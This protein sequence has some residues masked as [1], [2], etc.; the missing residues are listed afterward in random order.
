MGSRHR[1]PRAR[2]RGWTAAGL[3]KAEVR[4][5]AGKTAV[6]TSSSHAGGATGRS[7]RAFARGAAPRSPDS[8]G[9]T[10]PIRR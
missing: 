7:D 2:H 10:F 4:R 6:G 8:L 1:S 9:A 5:N 3:E